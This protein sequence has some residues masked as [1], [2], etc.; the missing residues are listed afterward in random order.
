MIMCF[1]TFCFALILNVRIDLYPVYSP[2][3]KTKKQN[4]FFLNTASECSDNEKLFLYIQVVVQ[5]L[6]YSTT[7]AYYTSFTCLYGKAE[8]CQIMV[9]SSQTINQRLCLTAGNHIIL[10]APH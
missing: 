10:L 9:H 2:A 4:F 3:E 7:H 1:L 8:L 5:V 6:L